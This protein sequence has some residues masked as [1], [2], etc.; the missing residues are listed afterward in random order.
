MKIN[1]PT[2]EKI[3]E[4]KGTKLSIKEA[5][6]RNVAITFLNGKLKEAINSSSENSTGV[7]VE[8]PM[9]AYSNDEFYKICIEE[10]GKLG[11][12][13]EKSHD[14]GGMY[15]TLYVSWKVKNPRSR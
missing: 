2:A 14:G 15:S 12:T 11:F 5:S 7:N 9:E 8:V 10:L 4:W 3:R 13:A 6:I 1:L